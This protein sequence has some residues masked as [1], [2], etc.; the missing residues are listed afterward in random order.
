M[1]K[2][3]RTVKKSKISINFKTNIYFSC[4]KYSNICIKNF[5]FN[6][7]IALT[8]KDN[9]VT[10]IAQMEG[11]KIILCDI[12]CTNGRVKKYFM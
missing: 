2:N 9:Y 4:I 5:L 3:F 1:Q 8:L 11:S 12:Y 6:N 10:Y 7:I